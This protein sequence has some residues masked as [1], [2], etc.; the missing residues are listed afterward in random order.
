MFDDIQDNTHF[1]DLVINNKIKNYRIFEFEGKYP[2]KIVIGQRMGQI[3]N[4]KNH[5][6]KNVINKYNVKNIPLELS[7]NRNTAALGA[8]QSAIHE[9]NVK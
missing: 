7:L 2:E 3:L 9:D 6:L 5:P 1:Y 8:A 4:E